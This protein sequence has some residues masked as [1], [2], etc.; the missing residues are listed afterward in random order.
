MN[1]ANFYQPNSG[2]SL[3]HT[4]HQIKEEK[5]KIDVKKAEV[6]KVLAEVIIWQKNKQKIERII[7]KVLPAVEESKNAIQGIKRAQLVEVRSMECPPNAVKYALESIC[8]LLGERAH[9]SF[10]NPQLMSFLSPFPS[11]VGNLTLSITFEFDPLFQTSQSIGSRQF[12][13]HFVLSILLT[14]EERG[15]GTLLGRHKDFSQPQFIGIR[16]ESRL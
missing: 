5:Q 11:A 8:L 10:R 15:G 7:L 1:R 6:E 12:L 14:S 9:P 2:S 4:H 3:S 13:P 16:Q